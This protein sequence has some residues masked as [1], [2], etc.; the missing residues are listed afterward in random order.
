MGRAAQVA[1]C[2]VLCCAM[3]RGCCKW[4][5]SSSASSV[6]RR[7]PEGNVSDHAFSGQRDPSLLVFTAHCIWSRAG[8][9]TGPQGLGRHAVLPILSVPGDPTKKS[10]SGLN[11]WEPAHQSLESVRRS[12]GICRL[13]AACVACRPWTPAAHQEW[14]AT[15]QYTRGGTR[16]RNLLLRREAP[17]PLGHTSN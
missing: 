4:A 1:H 5:V 17:Y 3:V 11:W 14:S 16:T 9:T 15:R 7:G 10:S 13:L 6:P 12:C 8:P 2:I